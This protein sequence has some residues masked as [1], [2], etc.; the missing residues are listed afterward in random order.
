[1]AAK[2]DP[3]FSIDLG[4]KWWCSYAKNLSRINRLDQ[5]RKSI[6]ELES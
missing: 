2:K 6:L 3:L 4:K 5:Q 1:M